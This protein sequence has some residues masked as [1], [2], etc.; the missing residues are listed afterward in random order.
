MSAAKWKKLRGL[1]ERAQHP[2]T[3]GPE[4][5]TCL[6]TALR[7]VVNLERRALEG[8]PTN[9]R[10]QRYADAVGPCRVVRW[11]LTTGGCVA[12]ADDKK[13]TVATRYVHGN[14]FY[15]LA[16]DGES[17]DGMFATMKTAQ[18]EAEARLWVPE[19]L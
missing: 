7:I 2:G 11:E 14:R 4:V 17:V 19:S 10:A 18:V 3:P 9:G 12:Y 8:P 6:K 1:L 15:V 5:A 16:F 13:I